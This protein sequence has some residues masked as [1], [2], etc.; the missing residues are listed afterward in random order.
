MINEY[1]FCQK[2]QDLKRSTF[3]ALTLL[4]IILPLL[5][6][7]FLCHNS[8]KS[9]V[10]ILAQMGFVSF[11]FHPNNPTLRYTQSPLPPYTF[12]PGWQMWQKGTFVQSGR[13]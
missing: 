6:A 13:F 10:S 2:R 8:Y 3:F 5:T 11:A 7:L 1:T 9:Q 4:S 12:H